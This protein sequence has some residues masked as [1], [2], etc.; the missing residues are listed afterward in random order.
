[1]KLNKELANIKWHFRCHMNFANEGQLLYRNDE[2]G[3]QMEIYTPKKYGYVDETKKPKRY[4]FIDNDK[5][6]FRSESFFIRELKKKLAKS[7]N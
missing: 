3:I 6:T 7:L 2:L 1:M 4:Y 5:R